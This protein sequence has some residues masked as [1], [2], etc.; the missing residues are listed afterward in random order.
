[1]KPL[2][3]QITG[4][5]NRGIFQKF[6][7]LL[8]ALLAWCGVASSQKWVPVTTPQFPVGV[9]LQ[10]T[11]GTIMVQQNKTSNWWRLT[12]DKFGHYNTGTWSVMPSMPTGYAPLY[13]ASAVLPDGRVIIEGGEYNN[14]IKSDTTLGA[15]YNPFTNSWANVPPPPGWTTIGDA[16][17]VVLPDGTFML[18]NC[19]GAAQAALLDPI[20]LNWTV[21]TSASGYLNKFDNNNEEGFTLLPGFNGGVL[22]IDTHGGTIGDT[23][24]NSEIYNWS[25]GIWSSAGSTVAQLWDSRLDCGGTKPTHEIG[26]AVLRPDGTVFATGSNTC[27]STAGHTSIYDTATGIWTPGF[28]IPGVNDAADA[29]ASIL[30]DGNVLVDTN[31]GWGKTPSTFYEYAAD[32]SGWVVIPQPKGLNPSNTEGGRML[33]TSAGT[34]L[35]THVNTAQL[36]VYKPAGTYLPA[37]QPT[38]T[39]YPANCFVGK[40][41]TVTGTQFNG[42][43]QGAAFGDDAQSATNYPLVQITNDITK[44]KFFARTHDHSTMAVATGA[45]VTFTSFDILPT[46]SGTEFGNSTLVVIANGIPSNPVGIIVEQGGEAGPEH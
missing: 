26:P 19:C 31:P 7:V 20:T 29:A 23:A 1:M 43:T 27:P 33:V 6:E 35:F 22:T 14:G 16:P 37:W 44:H 32:G 36:W 17:S 12:P 34:V 25:A 21:L 40:T 4:L 24:T 15:I 46:S 41:Y 9:A 30:T 42:F 13:F 3:L 2:H 45:A 39:T 38:I 11:D 5:G 10:L 8:V 28:D 18:G